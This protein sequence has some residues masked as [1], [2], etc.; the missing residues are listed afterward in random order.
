LRIGKHF[1]IGLITL[2]ML[3]GTL[4]PSALASRNKKLQLPK[5]HSRT[6]YKPGPYADIFGQHKAA[7]KQHLPKIS[8]RKR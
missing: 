1:L 2:L 7:K 8:H 5:H 3:G 4:S 6:H